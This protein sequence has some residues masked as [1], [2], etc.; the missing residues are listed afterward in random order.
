MNNQKL[1]SYVILGAIACICCIGI[2][3]AAFSTSLTI[4]GSAT[5]KSAAW[6]IKYANLA[7][8]V[9]TGTAKEVTAPTIS[10]ND[11][12]IGDYAVTLTTPGDSIKYTFDIKNEGTFDAEI[13]SV[14]VGTPECTGTGT[15]A[16]TD[17]ANVCKNLTYT[18]TY[19]DGTKV[20]AGDALAA[21]TSVENVTLTLT[22]NPNTTAAELPKNDVAISGLEVSTIY[23]QK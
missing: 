18:L 16:T 22:Y 2:G 23:S 19:A 13:S 4:N 3:Y 12:H 9:K 10:N 5:V 14:L 21:N 20:Q 1:K 8:A 6:D 11:T 7:S 15:N 17:A